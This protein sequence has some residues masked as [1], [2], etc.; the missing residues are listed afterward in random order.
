MIDLDKP[1]YIDF[2]L[3]GD[4]LIGT[5]E[6]DIHKRTA[7]PTFDMDENA[8]GPILSPQER[9]YEGLEHRLAQF[10]DD[11]DYT[12]MPEMIKIID[13]EGSPAVDFQQNLSINV[14]N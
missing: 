14:R 1:V 8:I 13:K 10:V 11:P 5:E 4:L 7:H 2:K 9:G 12:T 6:V 3:G